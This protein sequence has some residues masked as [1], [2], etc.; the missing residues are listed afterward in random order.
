MGFF[1][2]TGEGGGLIAVSRLLLHP[3]LAAVFP[4]RCRACSA[5]LE[6]PADGPLCAACWS[7]LPRHQA[8]LCE[9]GVPLP[10]SAATPCG[11][12]RR[13]LGHV[14]RGF[15]LGPYKGVLRTLVLELK[16]RSRRRLADRLAELVCTAPGASAALPEGALLV[17]VPLHPRRARQRGFNQSELLAAGISRR[18]GLPVAPRALLR[19]RDTPAQAGLSAAARRRNVAGAFVVRQASRV[20]GRTVVLVDDVLTTGATTRACALAL[21][22]AGAGAVHVLTLARVS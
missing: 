7:R 9:C 1:A 14:A 18:T 21:L 15:S 22:Q 8:P 16:Y 13:G 6:R 11:R 17:P 19:K 10:A 5:A 4:T 12:C 3:L 2:R 20:R